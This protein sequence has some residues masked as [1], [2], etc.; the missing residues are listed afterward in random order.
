[1]Q[2]TLSPMIR[3][4]TRI[5]LDATFLFVAFAFTVWFTLRPGQLWGQHAAAHAV[6]YVV[7]TAI[8]CATTLDQ[9]LYVSRRGESLT[10]ILFTVTRVYFI[11]LVLSG[12][13]LALFLRGEYSRP[14]FTTFA[15]SAL[16]VMLATVLVSRP[17]LLV[18][19]RRYSECR[20]LFVGADRHAAGLAQ[21]FLLDEHRTHHIVGYLDNDPEQGEGLVAL[22]VP[23]LGAIRDIEGLLI[24]RVI[25]EVYVSLPLGRF[26]EDVERIAHLCETIGV[27]VRLVGNMLPVQ[28]ADCDVAQIGDIP[29]LSLMTRPRYLTNLQLRRVIEAATALLLLV[30]LAP[31][32][33]LIALLLKL[34]SKG[35]VWVKKKASEGARGHVKLWSFRVHAPNEE[36]DAD[37]MP[38]LTKIGRVL[39]HYGFEDLPQL[40]NILLGQMTYVGFPTATAKVDA[41]NPESN[42]VPRARRIHRLMP[43]LVLAGFDACCITAAYVFAIRLTSLTP[44]LARLEMVNY[45]PFLCVLLLAWYAAAIERRLWR[46]RAVEPLGAA[47]LGLFKAVG[48]AAVVCGFLLA[49]FIPGV[50]STRQFLIVFFI[51]SFVAL[52]LFRISARFLTRISYLL[53]Y[54]ILRVAIVGAN[55]R[56]ERLVQA[57][58]NETRFGYKV[59]GVLEDEPSRIDAIPN[60]G[61]PYLGPVGDLA[62]LLRDRRIDE[63]YVTLPVRS[64]FD[65]IRDVLSVCAQAGMP[66][67]VVGNVLPLSIA[68]SRTVLIEDIPLISL[69]TKSEAYAWLAVKRLSDFVVSSILIVAFA[70]LF[71]LL[72]ALIKHDSQGPV[73]FVQ[74]RIG[75]NHRRFKMV[76]FRS[77]VSNAEALKKD[78][79]HLNEADGPVFKIKSDP[80]ITPLG[81]FLRKYSL[82]ELPQLFNVWLGHMSLV[83]PR[84]LMPHEVSEFAWFER[85]RLSVKPGMTG[86]WQV[87]GRSDIPFK[88]WV[89]MDL[90]YIDSWCFSQDML[91]LLKT[92]KAVFS[93]RGAA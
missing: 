18:L 29:L 54:R 5:V 14:F 24:D 20:V 11:A 85:R 37:G 7:F 79:M 72:A 15:L 22:G 23:Y 75:Q 91:I 53:R 27:P 57:L 67:H 80:R 12:F 45:L 50:Q 8:W 46:W 21:A 6:Y 66:V 93:G 9:H 90:A 16:A 49:V 19:R 51:L 52:L 68:K 13:C 73:F 44:N 39:R 33:A 74:D 56:T 82:D 64:H 89:E 81:H 30:A 86:S 65:A 87:S 58:G 78:I 40:I 3:L 10:A 36:H 60:S 25:D 55:E 92:F 62:A 61:G 48:N 83:G 35:P 71:L 31:L 59:V 38:R 1:M 42:V 2:L 84:P 28:L 76:K 32:L 63:V 34:E 41:G 88:E 17:G 43:T 47:A 77:M 70:P 4:L 26:Y 69:S